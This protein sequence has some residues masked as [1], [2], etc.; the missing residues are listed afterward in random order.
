[1]QASKN[2]LINPA[3][4]LAALAAGFLFLE[5]ACRLLHYGDVPPEKVTWIGHTHYNPFLI[6]GPNIDKRFPQKKN[7]DAWFNS[8]GFRM[9]GL[10]PLDKPAGEYRVFALGGSTTENIP[11]NDNKHY[12]G[13]AN[14]ILAQE[15]LNGKT[16]H[17][18]N[19]SKSG[20]SSAQTLVRLQFDLLA[21]KPDLITVMDQVNDL[22]VNFFPPDARTNYGNKYLHP[23]YAPPVFDLKR[24]FL[25]HS[26]ALVLLYTLFTDAKRLLAGKRIPSAGVP[27]YSSMRF[28]PEP[29]ELVYK[30]TFRD[31]LRSIAQIA[32]GHGIRAVFLT[33]PAFFSEERYALTFT[34]DIHGVLYP[35]L[36]EFKTLFA[37]YN[38]V[39][40]EVANEQGIPLIDM[41]ALMERNPDYYTDMIHFSAEGIQRF[42]AIYS[43][44]L[45]KII[46]QGKAA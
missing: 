8:Q 26:R 35:Q 21:F 6:F 27:V 33:Q 24:T 2:A 3:V 42:A 28:N 11:N 36:E 1:M 40:R 30:E 37:D 10:L 5:A 17:C 46:P 19:A 15:P 16:F 31:N 32:K 18:V 41:E 14:R 13:E 39:I 7:G 38:K 23:V 9:S 29:T 44:E 25:R 12:C 43:G 22:T 4:F 45:K 20:Y 34:G